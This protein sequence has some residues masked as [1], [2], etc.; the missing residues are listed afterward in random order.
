M[1]GQ[2]LG[3]RLVAYHMARALYVPRDRS[4]I[5]VAYTVEPILGYAASKIMRQSP[6]SCVKE[7]L[8]LVESLLIKKDVRG[9][10]LTKLAFMLA[11]DKA[12]QLLETGGQNSQ[13]FSSASLLLWLSH[14]SG[15]S[16][17]ELSQV[18][19]ME[20]S[21]SVQTLGDIGHATCVLAQFVKTEGS[22]CGISNYTIYQSIYT[23]VG[24]EAPLLTVDIDILFA[25]VI[26][27]DAAL[28]PANIVLVFG[29]SRNYKEPADSP[30]PTLDI[31]RNRGYTV[32]YILHESGGIGPF[33]FYVKPP[34][35]RQFFSSSIA[36]C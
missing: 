36:P 11:F 33:D 4:H 30:H 32:I 15:L 21:Q 1:A 26:D 17:S 27:E 23:S 9:E 13:L 8:T 16:V 25:C 20:N 18:H 5:T 3:E 7:V 12:S 24:I 6:S 22:A 14:L 2:E 19:A 34:G 29:Q 10:L 31:Y 28:E 35:A